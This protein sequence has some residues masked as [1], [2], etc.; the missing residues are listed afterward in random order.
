MVTIFIIEIIHFILFYR[1]SD[2]ANS[3]V[4]ASRETDRF[5]CQ[6]ANPPGVPLPLLCSPF[7]ISASYS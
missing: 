1:F 5:P 3:P 2:F 7:A 6:I 4:H